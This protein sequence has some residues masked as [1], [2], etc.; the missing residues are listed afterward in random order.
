M[1][2]FTALVASDNRKMER[3][4]ERGDAP[5][6]VTSLGSDVAEWEIELAPRGLGDQLEEALRVAAAGHLP[7]PPRLCEVLRSLVPLHLH[8]K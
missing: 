6:R 1:R 7:L 5:A 4:I 2:R 8:R 3:L